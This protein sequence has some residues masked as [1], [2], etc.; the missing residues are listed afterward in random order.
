MTDKDKSLIMQIFVNIGKALA[1]YESQFLP[2]AS[3]FDQY[4]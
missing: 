3:R 4:I 2:T 1:A